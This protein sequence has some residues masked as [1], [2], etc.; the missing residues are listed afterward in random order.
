M[1]EVSPEQCTAS[2]TETDAELVGSE[3]DVVKDMMLATIP[4]RMWDA[5]SDVWE[6]RIVWDMNMEQT[7][8]LAM[9]MEL[10]T[11]WEMDSK[12]K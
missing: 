12:Q 10:K 7:R 5:S 3:R 2:V 8:Q 1:A 11:L 6:Q 9:K 4:G